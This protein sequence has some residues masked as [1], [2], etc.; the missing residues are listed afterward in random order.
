[1]FAELFSYSIFLYNNAALTCYF[2][3][4]DS[5]FLRE[6]SFHIIQKRF[7]YF[8][9]SF[10]SSFSFS[11]QLHYYKHTWTGLKSFLFIK[12]TLFLSQCQGPESIG[13]VFKYVFLYY[14]HVMLYDGNTLA[15]CKIHVTLSLCSN[16]INWGRNLNVL[17]L[18]HFRSG[19][20]LDRK[21]PI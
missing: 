18:L 17:Q 10:F 15:K 6:N 3:Y 14:T 9:L 13:K 2:N 21:I 1:M 19:R 7:F 11:K 5:Y 8:P 12:N 16:D 20:N 4:H